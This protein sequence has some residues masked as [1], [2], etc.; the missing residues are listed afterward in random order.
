[1]TSIQTLLAVP[2]MS[3]PVAF[4]IPAGG[5]FRL[6]LMRLS[7][8]WRIPSIDGTVPGRDSEWT[9]IIRVSPGILLLCLTV[10]PRLVDVGAAIQGT[11]STRGSY[12][13]EGCTFGTSAG[14]PAALHASL[15]QS[16]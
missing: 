6:A 12:G 4:V 5:L 16:K 3:L 8:L 10:M 13:I 1:M 15:P 7:G 9:V 2:W 11:V 14:E